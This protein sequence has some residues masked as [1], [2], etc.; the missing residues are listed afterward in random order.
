MTLSKSSLKTTHHDSDWQP[1]HYAVLVG[2]FSGL[3]VTAAAIGSKVVDLWGLQFPAGL[4]VFPICCIITDLLS[5]IYGFNRARKAIYTVLAT[6]ILFAV[7]TQIAIIMP[8]PIEWENQGAFA[9]I[10]AN[11]PRIVLAGCL[12]WV[13]GELL[14]SFVISRL[15]I[16]Q[17][18]KHVSVRFI[19]STAVGQSAD[20]IVFCFVAFIG[21]MPFDMI[22]KL[23]ITATLFK[24]IYEVIALPVS[25][26][27]TNWL[28]QL[29][30]VEHF[31]DKQTIRWF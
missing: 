10:F 31:D 19:A 11:T 27:I 22:I 13:A 9:T 8:Y 2:L 26:S 29:E 18:A 24:I 6:T 25:I 1:K 7:F 5:E 28:K 21:V 14:N 15:K 12:A 20:S 23:I 17:K 3:Y 30:G 16:S 4:L